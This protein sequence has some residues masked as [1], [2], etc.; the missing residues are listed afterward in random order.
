MIQVAMTAAQFDA[1]RAELKAKY[2][3]DLTGTQGDVS[4]FGAKANYSFDGS[5]F[6][7][8]VTHAPFPFSVG[9]CEKKLLAD[10]NAN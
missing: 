4:M 9:Y 10:L 5:H 8:T 3:V 1:K 2:G 7:A 6:R